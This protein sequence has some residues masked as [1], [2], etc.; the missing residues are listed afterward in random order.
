MR[1]LA[2]IAMGLLMGGCGLMERPSVKVANVSTGDT[3]LKATTIVFDMEVTNPYTVPLPLT[4]ADYAISTGGQQFL[5]G[6]ADIQGTIPA[7]G[8]K[9]LPFPVEVRYA[10][11]FAAVK[12]VRGQREIP[13][14]AD[15]GLLVDTPLTGTL[16][17]PTQKKGTLALPSARSVMDRFIGK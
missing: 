12:S 8:T 5:T 10:D 11:L 1:G 4:G 2:W 13:Y 7:G 15:L 3:S 6:K 9:V 16:R 17:V 14:T